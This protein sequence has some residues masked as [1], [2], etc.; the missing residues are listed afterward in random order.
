MTMKSMLTSPWANYSGWKAPFFI[1][2]L[3]TFTL[4]LCLWYI[5]VTLLFIG[6]NLKSAILN[7][8]RW[9]RRADVVRRHED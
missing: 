3:I 8:L 1:I 7:L 6:L 9:I 4:L 2:W 5:I